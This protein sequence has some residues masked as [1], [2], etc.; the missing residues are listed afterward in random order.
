MLLPAHLD[1][2]TLLQPIDFEWWQTWS[3]ANR[4]GN[5]AMLEVNVVTVPRQALS[6][7]TLSALRERVPI[8][9]RAAAGV[10]ATAAIHLPDQ[11]DGALAIEVP[12]LRR[13][14]DEVTA[15]AVRYVRFQQVDRCR[16]SATCQWTGWEPS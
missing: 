10:P 4:S 16:C 13:R 6:T 5:S 14:F 8:A 2:S 1:W 7:R 3:A 15:A 9:L 11:R 12:L